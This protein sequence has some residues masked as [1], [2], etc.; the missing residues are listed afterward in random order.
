MDRTELSRESQGSKNVEAERTGSLVQGL[1]S[2]AKD[3]PNSEARGADSSVRDPKSRAEEAPETKQS[4]GPFD[5]NRTQGDAPDR[6][7]GEIPVSVDGRYIRP[8]AQEGDEKRP[9]VIVTDSFGNKTYDVD[10]DEV[11]DASHGALSAS[12]LYNDG[13]NVVG[14]HVGND[15]ANLKELEEDLKKGAFP[16]GTPIQMSWGIDQSIKDYNE[17]LGMN[18]TPEN[19]RDQRDSIKEKMQEYVKTHSNDETKLQDVLGMA[20]SLEQMKFVERFQELGHPVVGAAANSGGTDTFSPGLMYADKLGSGVDQRNL[21]SHDGERNGITKDAPAIFKYKPILDE[22]GQL[23]GV[24]S[25]GDKNRAEI[26]RS[27]LSGDGTF[28]QGTLLGN[29]FTPPTI[30][31]WAEQIGEYFEDFPRLRTL[32]ERQGTAVFDRFVPTPGDVLP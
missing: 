26:P 10:G 32:P 7:E 5:K 19:L 16:K 8:E 24:S 15:T 28:V 9:T 27:Q 17:K 13:F 29:S 3:K 22:N 6:A 4:D 11:P 2:W 31:K 30:I 21:P 18:L 20:L 1:E 12:A 14:F 25:N 23:T